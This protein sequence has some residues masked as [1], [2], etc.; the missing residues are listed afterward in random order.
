MSA[1]G[2]AGTE[3]INEMY[4]NMQTAADTESLREL[5]KKKFAPTGDSIAFAAR[6]FR[7]LVK[8]PFPGRE[9]LHQCPFNN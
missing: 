2:G 3:T 1:P 4:K 7:E 5:L 8:P 9:F 6:F